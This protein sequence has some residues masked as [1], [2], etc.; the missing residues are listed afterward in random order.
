MPW[1]NGLGVTLEIWVENDELGQRFR[2]S[3]AAVVTDGLFSDFSGLQRTLVL[4]NGNGIILSH[5]H[6][7]HPRTI[8]HLTAP[9]DIAH[10]SGGDIT[11]ATLSNGPIDDLNIMTRQQDTVSAVAAHRAPTA[12]EFNHQEDVLLTC[13]YANSDTRITLSSANNVPQRITLPKQSLLIIKKTSTLTL[14][15]GQGISIIVSAV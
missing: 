9:L 15:H 7:S 6:H 11:Y 1:K 12:V 3:Q 8:N 5:E 14:E 2:I 4:L 13:F 10:F